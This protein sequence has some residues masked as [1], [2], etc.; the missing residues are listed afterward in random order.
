MCWQRMVRV[1]SLSTPGFGP[2]AS[3]RNW[4]NRICPGKLLMVQ[5]QLHLDGLGLE[6][7]REKVLRQLVQRNV[8]DGRRIPERPVRLKLADKGA[9]ANNR[10]A[11]HSWAEPARGNIPGYGS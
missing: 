8:N 2:R 11:A 10:W 3:C 5:P 9:G 1:C 6:G 4:P 7:P